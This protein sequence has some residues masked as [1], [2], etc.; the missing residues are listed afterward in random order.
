[1]KF[2]KQHSKVGALLMTAALGIT[3]SAPVSASDLVQIATYEKDYT[4]VS[5]YENVDWNA[6][7]QYKADFHAHSTN[8]DGG[9]LT[10][11]MVEDHY[12]K[13]FDILSMTDHSYTTP[14]WDQ[15]ALGAVDQARYA[16]ILAGVGRDGR[17]MLD[18]NYANEQSVVDHINSFWA[19]FNNA[20]GATMA[21]TIGNVQNLGGIT[22]INHPGRYTGGK[23]GG[24]TGIAASNDPSTVQ[25][26]VDLFMNYS[27]VVGMEIVNK[28]DNESKT[29]RILW[30]N[31]LQQTMPEGRFVWG[32]SND[33]T[34][35]V[36]ATG[37]AWNMMLMPSLSQAETRN[38]M[39]TGSFYSVSRV[40]RI[41]GI[42]ATLTNGSTMPGS[43]NANTLYLLDQ[44]TPSI[45]NI[46]VNQE[47]N[48]ITVSGA[49]YSLVEWIA[50]GT[51]IA[52]GSTIDLN[53]YESE[54]GSYVR[55]QLKSNTGIAFTQPFGITDNTEEIQVNSVKNGNGQA[56]VNFAISSA[57]G[58]GYVVLLSE[59]G[60]EG[61]F[62]PYS[63]VNYNAQGA[64]IKGLENGKEYFVRVMSTDGNEVLG[65]S[66]TTPVNPAK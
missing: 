39:E 3:I 48:T 23:A 45:S 1:M 20:A 49:D 62:A 54:I 53:D 24:A 42:N 35:S 65:L 64:H 19:D 7:G 30:D 10:S 60:E 44:S 41:D 43:G 15:T 8:S 16:E 29:D 9:N 11:E 37:Y 21:G 55:A 6:Y 32:F 33:D 22:H 26:Y 63:N 27:S 31:I 2:K 14:S 58:K 46:E 61:T 17:G 59:T 36:N 47:E 5:P 12:A 34:H 50:D 57:N 66:E 52:T 13:G 38:A 4:I 40:S 18:I 56:N 28:I 25:K 51:V